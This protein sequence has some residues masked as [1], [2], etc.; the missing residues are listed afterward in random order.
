MGRAH[1][2][3]LKTK[4]ETSKWKILSEYNLD[5]YSDHWTIC[6]PNGDCIQKLNFTIWGNGSFGDHI[7]NETLSNAKGCFVENYPHIDI[8][9]GKFTAQFQEDLDEFI[10][11]INL[12]DRK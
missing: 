6:R 9:F 11:K 7:G 3:L 4:L 1:I 8:Y 5:V 2:E 10:R 12:I